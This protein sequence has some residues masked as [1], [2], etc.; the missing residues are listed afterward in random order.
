M[1]G[2]IH[3]LQKLLP[4]PAA[5]VGVGDVHIEDGDLIKLFSQVDNM[6]HGKLCFS[7]TIVTYNQR[8]SFQGNSSF[9]LFPGRQSR[10]VSG[11][12]LLLLAGHGLGQNLVHDLQ[13][14][15]ARGADD[16]AQ[17]DHVSGLA[18]AHFLLGD[19][20]AVHIVDVHIGAAGLVIDNGSVHKQMAAEK[21]RSWPPAH[22]R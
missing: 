1:D 21:D 10:L 18:V 16:G 15:N 6:V 22:R 8:N 7:A 17:H 9:L 19:V 5:E 12:Q 3:V 13:A 11:D 20:G 2:N 4:L 14:H